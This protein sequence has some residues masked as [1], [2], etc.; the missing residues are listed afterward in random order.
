MTAASDFRAKTEVQLGEQ[1]LELR[2]E[3]VTLRFQQASGQ[4]ENSARIKVVRRDIARIATV[5][6]E[7]SRKPGRGQ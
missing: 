1:M 7:K 4:L 2:K 5:L 3:R 6:A